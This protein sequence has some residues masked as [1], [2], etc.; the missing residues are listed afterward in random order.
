LNA[1]DCNIEALIVFGRRNNKDWGAISKAYSSTTEP[2]KI[3]QKVL[4]AG[5]LELFNADKDFV[6]FGGIARNEVTNGSDVD[7]TLLIDGQVDSRV[8][9]NLA[10][11]IK[12]GLKESRLKDPGP[13][14]PFGNI[15]FSHDLVHHI[16]G[17]DDTNHNLTQ[18]NLLLLESEM[19]SVTDNR[20]G[21]AYDRVLKAVIEQYIDNDSGYRVNNP[22]PHFTPRF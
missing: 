22:N 18:R 16:G 9:F 4:Q 10:S 13:K 7:W 19:V 20:N 3:V 6:V 1:I 11:F 21:T 2:K 5:D 14:G 8:N 12:K 15:T 17:Q